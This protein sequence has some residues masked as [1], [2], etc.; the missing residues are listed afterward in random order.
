MN[1]TK[2]QTLGPHHPIDLGPISNFMLC[3]PGFRLEVSY[4]GK[5]AGTFLLSVCGSGQG[6]SHT[7][8]SPSIDLDSTRP[9]KG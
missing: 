1:Q 2:L 6:H 5:F 4:P 8:V 3:M 7:V 9:T